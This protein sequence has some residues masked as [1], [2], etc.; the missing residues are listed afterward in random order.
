M[1]SYVESKTITEQMGNPSR[2]ILKELRGKLKHEVKISTKIMIVGSGS[3]NLVTR[4]GD[5]NPDVD[6]NLLIVDSPN[7]NGRWV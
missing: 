7:Y 5:K 4:N 2:K 1:Y 3:Y 6:Y